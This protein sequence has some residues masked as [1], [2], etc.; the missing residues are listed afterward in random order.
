MALGSQNSGTIGSNAAL[1]SGLREAVRLRRID[2]AFQPIYDITTNRLFGLEAL[3]RWVDRFFPERRPDVIHSHYAD[4]GYVGVR[5][6][7]L[8][9]V[10]LVHTG[11]SLGRVKQ[12]RLLA[13]GLDQETLEKRYRI[14]QRIAAEEKVL[15]VADLIVASTRQEVEEQYATY[16]TDVGRRA[17]VIPP[18]VDLAKSFI[19][20]WHVEAETL[21]I[22]IDL[23]LEPEHPFYETPRPAEKV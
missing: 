9:G 4:T 14:T 12:A 22:D 18:G 20:S 1:L 5:A 23:Y 7:N 21:V 3:A 13:K 15:E 8:L 19:L 16:A 6:A 17:E 10:H 2:V 11:H